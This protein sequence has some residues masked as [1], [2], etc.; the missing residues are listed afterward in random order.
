M[1]RTGEAQTLRGVDLHIAL[2]TPRLP[3]P[4]FGALR[5]LAASAVLHATAFVIA[6]WVRVA[7][8]PGAHVRRPEPIAAQEEVDSRHI[9][10]LAPDLYRIGS[11]GGGGG[12]QQSGPIRRA[13]GVGSDAIILRVRKSPPAPAPVTADS[14]S[15]V[16]DVSPLPS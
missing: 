12:N 13:Q 1:L 4:R 11:G 9:V 7:P 10:F 5:R 16:E 8:T 14:L 15:L 2:R 6:A 3:Q